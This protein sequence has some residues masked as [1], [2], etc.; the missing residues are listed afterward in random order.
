MGIL[1]IRVTHGIGFVLL[2]TA[3]LGAVVLVWS[4][5]DPKLTTK[6]DLDVALQTKSNFREIKKNFPDWY[7]THLGR[8]L[9]VINEGGDL[10]EITRVSDQQFRLFKAS[11]RQYIKRASSGVIRDLGNL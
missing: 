10:V 9:P 11:H 7:A 1:P 3:A 5:R 2:C 4:L 8:L 6:A